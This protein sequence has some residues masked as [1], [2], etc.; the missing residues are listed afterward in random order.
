MTLPIHCRRLKQLREELNL[1]QVAFAKTLG[2]GSTTTEYER[3]R[4]KLTGEI[5]WRLYNMYNINPDWLYGESEQKHVEDKSLTKELAPSVV[6]VENSGFENILM[7]SHKAAAGYAGNL[8]NQEFYEQLPAFSFPIPEYRN[9][10]Y[11]CFQVEGQSMMPTIHPHDWVITKAIENLDQIKNNNIYVVVDDEGIRIKRVYNEKKARCL[12]LLSINTAFEQETVKY[13]NV[14]EVWEFH[15]K[16]TKE[17]IADSQEFKLDTI[18]KD[19]KQI[20]K[21]LSDAFPAENV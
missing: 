11:R 18:Y 3:G 4:T 14:I 16:L 7:V 5:V 13:D 2:I 9:A 17:L 20:K 15:S 8:N 19:I 21:K 1:T 10:T 12:F 6:T